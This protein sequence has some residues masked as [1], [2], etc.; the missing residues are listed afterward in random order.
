M[1]KNKITYI[2]LVLTFLTVITAG[3]SNSPV[4]VYYNQI[5]QLKVEDNL[6]AASKGFE[7][8]A[9]ECTSVINNGGTI[10]WAVYEP[11]FNEPIKLMEDMK[12]KLEAVETTD[13]EVKDIHAYLISSYENMINGYKEIVKGMKEGNQD[14]LT[15]A[16]EKMTRAQE[17]ILV[18]QEKLN[19]K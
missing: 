11:K 2:L 3:C 1:R 12:T 17:D 18:W 9:G 16:A 14:M 10:D 8:V 7:S 6:D 19:Q 15:Q 5:N 4:S 13:Q